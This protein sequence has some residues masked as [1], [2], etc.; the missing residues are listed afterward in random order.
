MIF[1]TINNY[2]SANISK[3]SESE[4]LN[5]YKENFENVRQ[6][7]LTENQEL[8]NTLLSFQNNLNR[9]LNAAKEQFVKIYFIY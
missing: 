2:G 4:M 9:I 7:I 8:R 6:K 3:F 1:E 5:T